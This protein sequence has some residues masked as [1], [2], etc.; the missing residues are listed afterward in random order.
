M[1]QT[2]RP[3]TARAVAGQMAAV[4]NTQPKSGSIEIAL[5]PEELGRV[6]IMLNGRDDGLHLTI[7]AERPETL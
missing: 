1:V 4:I 5:N 3:E 7:S 2:A 6:S